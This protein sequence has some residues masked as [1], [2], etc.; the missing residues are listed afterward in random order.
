MFG[1]TVSTGALIVYH[2]PVA[3]FSIF[4]VIPFIHFAEKMNFKRLSFWFSLLMI[5]GWAFV[6]HVV[7]TGELVPDLKEIRF[8]MIEF[9]DDF[10][11]AGSAVYPI[12][13]CLFLPNLLLMVRIMF[14]V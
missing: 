7:L 1:I 12:F 13:C 4:F 3:L 6:S 2:F 9:E 14:P 5:T 11:E 8:K 10:L